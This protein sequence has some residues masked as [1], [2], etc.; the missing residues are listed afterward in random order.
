MACIDA[1]AAA[2]Y[3]MRRFRL[4]AYPFRYRFTFHS[5]RRKKLLHKGQAASHFRLPASFAPPLRRRRHADTITSS[6][7]ISLAITELLISRPRRFMSPLAAS[8]HRHTI[9]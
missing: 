8:P 5:C 4:K 7:P 6:P 2:D 9:I 1:G 3:A